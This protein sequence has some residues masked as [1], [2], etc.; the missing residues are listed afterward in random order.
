MFICL[1]NEA[2][3]LLISLSCVYTVIAFF[4]FPSENKSLP[5]ISMSKV[6]LIMAL[7][8]PYALSSNAEMPNIIFILAD[9]LGEYHCFQLPVIHVANSGFGDVPWNNP[10]IIAP[11]LDSLTKSG[12]I[13]NQ[14][15][16]LP[17]C[18]PSRSALL[19]GYYTIK[20][21]MHNGI[22]DPQEPSGLPTN[23]TLLPEHFRTLGYSTHLIGKLD[24]ARKITYR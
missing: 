18:S 14:F 12:L 15:Y 1:A 11:S 17:N 7:V 4:T 23:F 9:D 19:T 13:L 20:T 16:V 10:E 22:V 2:F 8:A 21:G 5:G 6:I 3:D 24:I